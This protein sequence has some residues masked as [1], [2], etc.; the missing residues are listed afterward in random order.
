MV[1]VPGSG[2][3]RG[4]SAPGDSRRRRRTPLSFRRCRFSIAGRRRPSRSPIPSARRDWQSGGLPDDRPPARPLPGPAGTGAGRTIGRT[5][6]G[7]ESGRGNGL[8]RTP[9]P[10]HA[11][12][13]LHPRTSFPNLIRGRARRFGAPGSHH[14]PGPSPGAPPA[15]RAAFFPVAD[16]PAPRFLPGSTAPRPVSPGSTSPVP[17]RR[18]PPGTQSGSPP[19]PGR[20]PREPPP[21]RFDP[22]LDSICRGAGGE[23][24]G[25]VSRGPFGPARSERDR[26]SQPAPRPPDSPEPGSR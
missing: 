25:P 14:L 20:P 5:K 12:P 11:D 4:G 24:A 15:L 13:A 7:G 26:S 2:E 6:L 3:R 16:E 10:G 18:D 21:A 23:P 19:R 8:E 17:L 9:V 22:P 1:W